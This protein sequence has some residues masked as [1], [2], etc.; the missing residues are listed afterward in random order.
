MIEDSHH[1]RLISDRLF[2]S[3]LNF[4]RMT[5][6]SLINTIKN[7]GA[8]MPKN[9]DKRIDLLDALEDFASENNIN[10]QR[11]NIKPRNGESIWYE[12]FRKSE[13][14][15]VL[16]EKSKIKTEYYNAYTENTL[17]EIAYDK[18]TNKWEEQVSSKLWKTLK[19]TQSLPDIF[20]HYDELRTV[21]TFI[22]NKNAYFYA[23]LFE[24]FLNKD[25]IQHIRYL[26]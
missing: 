10:Y 6:L 25:I 21:T 26:L 18:V 5:N 4:N 1:V 24:E 7:W 17:R 16:F 12:T 11:I 9:I 23:L 14:N 15:L 19:F 2:T 13:V 8:A 22:E 3:D 20:Q